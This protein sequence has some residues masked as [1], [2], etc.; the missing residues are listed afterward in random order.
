M[1]GDFDRTV[2]DV[3]INNHQI[4]LVRNEIESILDLLRIGTNEIKIL[5]D[6]VEIEELIIENDRYNFYD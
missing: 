5:T 2:I 4:T 3:K 1:Y 6:K